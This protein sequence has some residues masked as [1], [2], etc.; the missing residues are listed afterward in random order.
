M[1]LS[2][3]NFPLNLRCHPHLSLQAVHVEICS[4]PVSGLVQN[5]KIIPVRRH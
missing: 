3:L 2:L 5:F 4:F 1:P